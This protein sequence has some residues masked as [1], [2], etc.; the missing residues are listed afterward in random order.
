MQGPLTT[1]ELAAYS[2]RLPPCHPIA[3]SRHRLP[4]AVPSGAAA[5][6]WRAVF[7]TDPGLPRQQAHRGAR[8]LTGVTV[9]EFTHPLPA[10]RVPI[11]RCK[12]DQ[13]LTLLRKVR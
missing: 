9:C 10:S 7:T 13:T 3:P 1:E 8:R 11:L 4:E 5:R 2:S 6:M 12:F